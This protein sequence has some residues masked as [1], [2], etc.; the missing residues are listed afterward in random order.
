[1]AGRRLLIVLPDAA[2][3]GGHFMNF[4]LAALLA[5]RGWTVS[6]AFLY[7]RADDQG[8]YARRYPQVRQIRLDADG[9]LSRIALPFRLAK[10]ARESDVI[11]AGLDLAAT[12]YSYLASLI[13]R[14]PLLV[15]MHIAFGT[16]MLSVSKLDRWLSLLVYRRIREIVFPS[17]GA[18]DSLGTA[19][20]HVP[21]SARWHVIENFNESAPQEPQ[22]ALIPAEI[23]SSPVVMSIGRLADQKAL[24]R[25]I[26]A[27]ASLLGKGARHHLVILGDGPK[28]AEL[29]ALI[30]KLCV[31]ESVWMPGHVDQPEAWLRQAALFA[32]CSEYEGLPLVLLEALKLG[33]PVVSMDCPAGPRE[34]LANGNAGRLTPNG[35]IQAFQEAIEELLGSPQLRQSLS[36]RGLERAKHYSAGRII[37]LWENLLDQI[38]RH[39]AKV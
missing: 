35:D 3:G 25:L 15:W 18:L 34:I 4:R 13:S 31:S 38:T 26:H 37:P 6:V 9:R 12:N 19:L 17:Q 8:H 7:A 10:L 36:E 39:D 2:L 24:H 23:F 1:M 32:L 29:E 30:V 21:A 14:R 11:V 20:G 5:E 16:H 22:P 28:R 33:V 27:H